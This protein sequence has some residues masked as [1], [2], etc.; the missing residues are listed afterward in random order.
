[1]TAP[2]AP[3]VV[4]LAPRLRAAVTRLNRRLRTS[5][6]GGI[7]PAQASALATIEKLGAPALNELAAAEQVRPP[8]MTRLVDALERD[9]LV[10]PTRRRVGPTVPACDADCRGP[11]GA[12]RHPAKRRRRFLRSDSAACPYEDL[13]AVGLRTRHPRAALGGDVRFLRQRVGPHLPVTGRPQLPPLLHRPGDLDLGH[14]DAVVRPGLVGGREPPGSTPIDL[15]SRSRCRSSRAAVRSVRR[16]RSSTAPTS[17]RSSTRPS[18]QAACSRSRSGS[19]SRLN[20]VSLPVIWT[21]GRP[22]GVV[23]LFDNPARQ[24][25][26][27]EMVGRELLPNAVSLNSALINMGRVVGPAIERDPARFDLI[28]ACFYVNAASYVAVLGR[29]RP[30][31]PGR[32]HADPNREPRKG[33]D[34]LRACATRGSNR[35]I[36]TVLDLGDCSSACSPST[37]R[38]RC[39]SS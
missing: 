27:Q 18:P 10:D 24:S 30:D 33:T 28:A 7:S 15:A 12:V 29:A 23:N 3:P 32:D 9:G 38:S 2:A 17:A 14:L 16:L 8:S 21:I 20:H 22:L 25:F 39:Q 31:A 6:L 26:V 37:S 11:P 19:W 36:R 1:M 13:D 5:S 34:R 4:D 35:E